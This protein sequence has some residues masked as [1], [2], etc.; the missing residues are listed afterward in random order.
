M[1]K[2]FVTIIVIIALSGFT[3]AQVEDHSLGLRFGSLFGLGTEISYQHG[4]N[5][6]NRLEVD[7]GFSS[8]YEYNNSSRYDY[9]SW[10][11]TGLYH[12]VWSLE[13]NF[14]WYAGPGAQIGS[15]NSM[16]YGSRYNNGL[17]L[18]AAGN[19]G[20]EYSFPVKIQIALDARPQ[21]GLL[22]SGSG[23]NIGLSVRYQF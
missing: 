20:I 18:A 1:K 15:W 9:N 12:W 4:L 8:R 16:I 17:F 2:F 10:A 13:N 22:N 23:I 7:L 19:V 6:I 14:N 3:S 21:L 11:L 5:N